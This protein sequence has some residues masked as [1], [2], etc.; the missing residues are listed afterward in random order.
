MGTAL[1]A[2]EG[3]N[4]LVIKDTGPEEGWIEIKMTLSEVNEYSHPQGR[5]IE[6]LLEYYQYLN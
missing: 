3:H 2:N 1:S 5:D 4:L 6:D